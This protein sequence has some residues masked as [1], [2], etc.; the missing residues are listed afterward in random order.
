MRLPS[1][2]SS[3]V[4]LR[5]SRRP[6]VSATFL[7]ILLTMALGTPRTAI[8]QDTVPMGSPMVLLHSETNRVL[9][10][11]SVTNKGQPVRGIEKG[12]FHIFEDGKEQ[13]VL[14]FEEQKLGITAPVAPHA[15]LPPNVYN[16]AP[17][18][19]PA[20]AVNVLLLDGLNTPV[21][22]QMQVRK[23]MIAYLGKIAPGTPLALFTLSSRLRL[24]QGFT[25]DPAAI[26]KAV[27]NPQEAARPSPVMD[28]TMEEVSPSKEMIAAGALARVAEMMRQFE[29]EN[30]SFKTDM[31]M[32]ITLQA[33]RELARYL[34]GIPGRKN[35]IWFSGSF[36]VS[37]I[38]DPNALMLPDPSSVMRVYEPQIRAATAMLAS[39]RVAM[40]PI[41]ARGLLGLSILSAEKHR[42]SNEVGSNGQ[43]EDLGAATGQFVS[44]IASNHETMRQVARETGGRAYIN[45]NDFGESIAQALADGAH[46][47]TVSYAPP[48]KLKDGTYH[49]IK[50]EID[51]GSYSL[52]YRG[53]Y[54]AEEAKKPAKAPENT[55]IMEAA[56]F[57]AP[58]ATQVLFESRVLPADAPDIVAGPKLADGPA[59]SLAAN[60]KPPVKRYVVDSLVN[61]RTLACDADPKGTRQCQL[62]VTLVGYAADGKRLNFADRGMTLKL[63]ADIY[64][65]R[66]ETGI[67]IR[68]VIDL[69][70][71][72][73]FLRIAVRDVAGSHIGS[74]E[75]P[76]QIAGK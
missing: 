1:I 13:P 66:L 6:I 76:L 37:I 30:S 63:S 25:Q 64:K 70:S 7:A 51:G 26:V 59:G 58:P 60:L 22:D 43:P 62:E 49:H 33:L 14:S 46:Y 4:R 19:P 28:T 21:Q 50:V 68:T 12:R 67:P 71:G 29:A 31:R 8:S 72:K 75:I 57:G 17:Q 52:S 15:A 56:Q 45:T 61:T 69:P 20:T 47:Y 65:R 48:S 24:V 73:V 3:V 55:L 54:F 35:L 9:V 2:A 11:I 27:N 53:G 18:Y 39:A 32:T 10:D 40:Y 44:D 38:P 16:N 74:T 34:G 23:Q 41:D 36:P 5:Q 42:F